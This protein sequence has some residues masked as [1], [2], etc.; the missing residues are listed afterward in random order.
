ML[1]VARVARS[2]RVA[3]LVAS[4]ASALHAKP[5]M[6]RYYGGRAR[7]RKRAARFKS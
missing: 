1:V 6:V 5:S 3:R 7:K 4:L 2:H